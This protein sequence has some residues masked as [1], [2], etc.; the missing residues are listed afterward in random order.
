MKHH[1]TYKNCVV[2]GHVVD[3]F[4]HN[5]NRGDITL[6]NCSAHDNG[7]NISFGSSNIANALTIKYR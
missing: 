3:G 1:A 6:Y 4:D 7:R 2:S 5:S